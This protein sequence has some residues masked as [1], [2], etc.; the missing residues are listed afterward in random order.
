MG[1]QTEP[2]RELKSGQKL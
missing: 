1:I 2:S